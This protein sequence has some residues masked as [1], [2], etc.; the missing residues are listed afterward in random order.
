MHI[1]PGKKLVCIT[2]TNW[3]GRRNAPRRLLVRDGFER[4][5]WFT[6]ERRYHD[7]DFRYLSETEFHLKNAASEVH[8]YFE[9]SGSYM[10]ILI[11]EIEA[12]LEKSE[13]GA[14]IVGPPEIAEQTAEAVPNCIVFALKA[15]EMKLSQRLEKAR[16]QGQLHRIDVDISNPGAWSKVYALISEKLGIDGTS[17]PF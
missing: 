9:Y 15:R 13:R 17:D 10:G 2:G 5:T 7:A 11:E 4:P 8:A 12:A 16:R 14:L 6:T 3:T 1:P